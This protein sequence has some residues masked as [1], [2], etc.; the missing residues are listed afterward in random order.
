MSIESIHTGSKIDSKRGLTRGFVFC[1]LAL[2]LSGCAAGPIAG[3]AL[4]LA[5][6]TLTAASD[7]TSNAV[8]SAVDV[9]SPDNK[10]ETTE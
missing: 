9:V 3:A 8:G 10:Q 1:L 2:S 6:G 4:S 5:S 7:V